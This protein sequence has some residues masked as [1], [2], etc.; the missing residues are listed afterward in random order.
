MNCVNASVAAN[1]SPGKSLSNLLL[2][3]T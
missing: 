1:G 3:S 2:A